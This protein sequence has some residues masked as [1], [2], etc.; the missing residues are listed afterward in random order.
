MPSASHHVACVTDDPDAVHRFLTEVVGL[1]VH[2]RF[3]VSGSDL[4]RT[5]GWPEND[6][7]AV[8]M[9]GRPPAGI[10][11][12]IAIPEALRGTVE[13]KLWLVSFAT[14]EVASFVERA[15]GLGLDPSPPVPTR[16]DVN[17]T[18]SIVD[19]G[20]VTWEFVSFD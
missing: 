13:P 9:Y 6:G 12:V 7:A 3:T 1:E 15:R 8:T 20:G 4:A 19:V 14:A 5:A 18:T 10:V 16:G 17:I 11:E 2:L